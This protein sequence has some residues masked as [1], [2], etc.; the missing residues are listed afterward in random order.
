[1]TT[2]LSK[3][4]RTALEGLRSECDYEDG[5]V[6]GT[7]NYICRRQI[8]YRIG[9]KTMAGLEQLDLAKKGQNKWNDEIAW[10]ITQTGREALQ[11]PAPPKPPRNPSRLK[12]VPTRLREVKS[13]LK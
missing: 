9:K 7:D 8:G 4:M 5:R 13:R 2:D 11:Q 12:T 1:M 10:R 6:G 3:S